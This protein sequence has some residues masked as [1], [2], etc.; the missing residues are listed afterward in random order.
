LEDIYKI[1]SRL[2][3]Q[4]KESYMYDLREEEIEMIEDGKKV[5]KIRKI[6][7]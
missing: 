5:K 1:I 6:L 4:S 2:E 7:N 3:K